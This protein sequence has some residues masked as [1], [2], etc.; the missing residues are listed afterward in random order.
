M[1]NR[2]DVVQPRTKG[3]ERRRKAHEFVS[4][5]AEIS[6]D[7][8]CVL[9]PSLGSIRVSPVELE[10]IRANLRFSELLPSD[11]IVDGFRTRC[12]VATAAP[13]IKPRLSTK[14]ENFA[15]DD[16]TPAG[17]SRFAWCSAETGR[18]FLEDASELD[19]GD[20]PLAE[21]EIVKLA[22]REN[23]EIEGG[24]VGL[25]RGGGVVRGAPRDP[26]RGRGSRL[27]PA[28]RKGS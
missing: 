18:S 4:S 24:R 20:A 28:R 9:P 17:R 23:T 15:S 13:A 8:S 14:A 19:G 22:R 11:D 27:H 21:R 12:F 1:R 3:R 26:G 25:G 5:L 16:E 2:D 6:L 7:G 10:S